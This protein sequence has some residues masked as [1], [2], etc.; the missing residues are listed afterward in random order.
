MALFMLAGHRLPLPS[1]GFSG[2]GEDL[3]QRGGWGA[4]LLG[5]LF[6]L[7]FCPSSG[8]LYFGMLIPLSATS[9]AGWLLPAVFAVATALP[10]LVIAWILAFSA[11]RIGTVYGRMQTVRKWLN[12][13]VGILFTAVGTYYCITLFL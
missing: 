1:F 8:I 7:A 11:Q 4:F 13:G 5:V 9:A 2:R 6:A 12:T 3:A 10:V